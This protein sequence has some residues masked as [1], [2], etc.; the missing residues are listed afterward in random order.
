MDRR[1][2]I[3][4]I[5]AASAT[6]PLLA[7]RVGAT[8][9]ESA[10]RRPVTPQGYGADPD[11]ARTYRPGDVWPLTFTPAQR[12]TATVLCDL[13]IPAD[14]VSP[15]ATA[16]GVVDFIDEWVSAPYPPQQADRPVVLEGLAWLD[17]EASRRYAKR[18]ADLDFTQQGAICDDIAYEP[19]ARPAFVRAAR[20][21]TRYRDLTAGGFYSTPEGRKDIQ[22]IGNVP[23]ARFDGPPLEVLRRV[24][25]DD[26]PT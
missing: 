3:Q 7:A 25:L 9:A 12:R 17:E 11:L 13:I 14:P 6:M 10:A 5:L 16:V 24:G 22:Y 18:F 15:G 1:R 8:G 26:I 2:T 4:W 21:F 23:L 20:F 19:K